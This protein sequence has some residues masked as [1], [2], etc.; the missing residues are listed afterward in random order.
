M[1]TV[2]VLF[3]TT[4]RPVVTR[5]MDVTFVVFNIIVVFV[6]GCGGGRVHACE[7]VTIKIH[8]NSIEVAAETHVCEQTQKRPLANQN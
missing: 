2:G 1:L 3:A 5:A 7:C 4:R 8:Q 6:V